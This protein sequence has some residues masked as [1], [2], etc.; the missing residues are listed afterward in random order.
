MVGMFYLSSGSWVFAV[1]L[2]TERSESNLPWQQKGMQHPGSSG[3]M[4]HSTPCPGVSSIT[5]T[6]PQKDSLHPMQSQ[7]NS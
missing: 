1:C 6:G 7:G 2:V 5:R 4:G 3:W